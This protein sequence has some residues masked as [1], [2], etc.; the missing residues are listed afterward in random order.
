MKRCLKSLPVFFYYLRDQLREL[1][2]DGGE[3]VLAHPHYDAVQ[4]RELDGELERWNIIFKIILRK[5][6]GECPACVMALLLNSVTTSIRF[7][8]RG[9]GE[10]SLI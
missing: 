8:K 6:S 2:V 10:L 9:S 4:E 3:G 5:K 7:Q 1:H